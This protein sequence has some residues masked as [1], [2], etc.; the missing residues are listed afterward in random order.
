MAEELPH[1]ELPENVIRFSMRTL[2]IAM[3]VLAVWLAIASPFLRE[4]PAPTWE[5]LAILSVSTV[6][7]TALHYLVTRYRENRFRDKHSNDYLLQATNQQSVWQWTVYL[8]FMPLLSIFVLKAAAGHP[9]HGPSA[10]VG[11]IV[12][13]IGGAWLA[14]RL[15]HYAMNDEGIHYV[16]GMRS[17]GDIRGL[18]QAKQR[19]VICLKTRFSEFYFQLPEEQRE[20]V[21]AFIK[22]KTG[23]ELQPSP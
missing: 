8:V 12:G 15:K 17:W 13:T 1:A 19:N 22:E 10:Y 16:W 21:L 14:E 7:F 20:E 23:H 2:L 18:Y 9:A 6:F 5:G 3:T 11:M 4:L